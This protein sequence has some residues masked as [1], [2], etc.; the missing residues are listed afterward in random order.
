MG[1]SRFTRRSGGAR[2]G[3]IAVVGVFV[4]A[5]AC[6]TQPGE[7]EP[8]DAT[9]TDG[10]TETTAPSP[11]EAA[12]TPP[13]DEAPA[14]LQGSWRTTLDEDLGGHS[15]TLQLLPTSYRITRAGNQATGSISVN[16]DQIEF[17][18][19]TLCEGSG[20]YQWA[21]DGDRLTLTPVDD[22]PCTGRSEVIIGYTYTR[23]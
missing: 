13:E 20:T 5:A 8:T 21:I 7:V 6:S 15:V 22:D 19:S 14:E 12:T 18:G 2:R 16:G 4:L 9:P 11:T 23:V 17:F 1:T 3:L 10:A